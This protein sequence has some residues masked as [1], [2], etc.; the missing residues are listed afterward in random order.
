MSTLQRLTFIM[1]GFTFKVDPP[2]AVTDY[3]G[4]K[5]LKPSFNWQDVWA[6]EH[7]FAFTVAKATELSVLNDIFDELQTSIADGTPFEEFKKNLTPKLKAR[8]WWGE[9]DVVDPKTGKTVKARLGSP[10]RLQT[11]YWANVRTARAAGQWERIQNTASILPYLSYELGPSEV[12]RPLHADKQGIVL[13]A[14]DPFWREWFAPN[15]WGCKCWHRQLG[16]SEAKRLGVSESPKIR[17]VA[18]KNKRTGEITT[19]PEGIDPG[20]NRNPGFEREANAR[21]FLQGELD[22]APLEFA[23]IAVADL[24]RDSEFRAHVR[25]ERLTPYIPIAVLDEELQNVLKAKTRTVWLSRDSAIDHNE[26]IDPVKFPPAEIWAWIQERLLTAEI[27]IQNKHKITMRFRGP[28][29][30]VYVAAIKVTGDLKE[31]YLVSFG[32][33]GNKRLKNMRGERLRGDPLDEE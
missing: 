6:Q 29:K 14:T 23:R 15:G 31:L 25:G 22:R 4:N 20:W 1:E 8:G 13:P 17:R 30:T 2:K 9:K 5:G 11:I 24:V 7:A 18:H 10:R 33:R 28:D 16:P 26:F 21:S 12:H 27:H 32:T 3:L 19:A